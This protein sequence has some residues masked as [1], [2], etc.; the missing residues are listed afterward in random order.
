MSGNGKDV[1]EQM[2]EIAE[3]GGVYL[4]TNLDDEFTAEPFEATPVELGSELF[5]EVT[6]DNGV[7]E[8]GDIV[9][10]DPTEF[11]FMSIKKVE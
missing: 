2:K 10:I 11:C 5:V 9:G 3:N 6:K 4:F 8:K 7:L 1:Y